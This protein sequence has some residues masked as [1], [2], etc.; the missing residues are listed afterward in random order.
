M[1]KPE[2]E[3]DWIDIGGNDDQLGFLLFDQ[4]GDVVESALEEVGSLLLDLLFVDFVLGLF[5]ESFSLLL[6]V[7]R[8]VLLQ[9]GEKSLL[10]V[11]AESVR[12]LVDDCWDLESVEE[13]FSL[14]LKQDVLWP[15]NV[16]RQVSFLLD[17]VADFVISLLGL[18]E[19][20]ILRDFLVFLLGLYHGL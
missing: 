3:L 12:E 20:L 18:E 1:W 8:L 19:I 4:S 13:D 15:L 11:R 14:P 5:L 2:D 9:K 6:L 17:V 16:P 10:L 7:L